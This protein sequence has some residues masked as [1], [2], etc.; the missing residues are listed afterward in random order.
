MRGD[1]DDVRRREVAR[2]GRKARGENGDNG[3]EKTE[4]LGRRNGP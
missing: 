3:C 4:V 2:K 1:K